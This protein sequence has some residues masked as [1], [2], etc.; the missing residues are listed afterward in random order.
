MAYVPAG[1]ELSLGNGVD[2]IGQKA[3]TSIKLNGTVLQLT[4]YNIG[5]NNYF[6]LRDLAEAINFGVGW[7]NTNKTILIDTNLDYNK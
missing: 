6:K 4:A 2:T 1:G 7:N 3:T 5:G